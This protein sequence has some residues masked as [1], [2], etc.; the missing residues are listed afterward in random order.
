MKEF[1]IGDLFEKPSLKWCASRKFNKKKDL[2]DVRTPEFDLPL[3]NAKNGN[4]GIMYYGR[5]SDFN[6]VN[7]G[8]DIIN[9]GAISTGNVYPQ[10]HDIGVLYNAYIIVLKNGITDRCVLEYLSCVLQKAIK[11]RFGYD[12]KATWSKVK[13]LYISLPTT[14]NGK[15][16]WEYMQ[17]YI[18]ELE[19]E[20]I[21]ELEQ[22]LVATGLND[23]TLTDEDSGILNLEPEFKEFRIGDLFEKQTLK[24]C[25][26][27]EFDKRTDVST[28]QSVEFDLPLVNAKHGNNGIMYYGRKSDFEYVSGGIDIVNDGAVST[29]NVYPQ[30]HD[31]G[32]LYNAY[33]VTLKNGITSRKILEYL[34]CRMQKS[35]KHLFSYD[36]KAVWN[37]VKNSTFELPIKSDGEPDWDYMAAYIR[38]IE[39][40]VIKDVVDFKD[41]FIAGTTSV[42]TAENSLS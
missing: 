20:R 23:Y 10:P 22:Y 38:A 32:V 33:I 35:I 40:L 6:F 18:A 26:S 37:K 27:H 25:G 14:S 41:A 15:P 39:K 5:K 13:D 9:D 11:Y 1:R 34:A 8:I 19:Q 2:S 7:G 4:N 3:V 30:P 29:G 36:N 31:I 42:V 16:D 17:K 21:A 12:N 24:W 28:E